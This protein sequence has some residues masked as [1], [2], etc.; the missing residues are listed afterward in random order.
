[1]EHGRNKP[2][3]VIFFDVGN[4]LL[5]PNRAKMLAPIPNDRHPTLLQWQALERRTKHDFDQSMQTGRVDHGFW[6][7]FHTHLLAD[8][9]EDTSV[10]EKLVANSQNSAHWDQIV[11][12]TRDAGTESA[13]ISALPL[14]PM[15]MAE[16]SACFP[17]AGSP[18]ALKA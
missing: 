3:R 5:F 6:W 14:S 9:G 4:T 1:M 12:G 7:T 15:L 18:I 8:L 10:R 11:P 13:R 17:V 16:S 2:W